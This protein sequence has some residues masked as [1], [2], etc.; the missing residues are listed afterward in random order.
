MY[1]RSYSH[2]KIQLSFVINFSYK[3]LRQITSKLFGTTN[4]IVRSSQLST[5]NIH[6]TLNLSPAGNS[7]RSSSLPNKAT[8]S[9]PNNAGIDG[10]PTLIHLSIRRNGHEMKIA[11]YW[12]YTR[13]M[14][15]DGR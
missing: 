9:H 3:S 6:T 13:N 15:V 2:P 11:F 12:S 5:T 1:L 14:G 8:R 7:F 10:N 4:M